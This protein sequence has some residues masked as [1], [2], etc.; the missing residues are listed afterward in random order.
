MKMINLHNWTSIFDIFI[1][2][3]HPTGLPYNRLL[4]CERQV[5]RRTVLFPS[6]TRARV[7]VCDW[8][9]MPRLLRKKPGYEHLF[10]SLQRKA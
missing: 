2:V 7:T 8:V 4:Y 6:H 1:F 10:Q 5:I 9:K 3:T